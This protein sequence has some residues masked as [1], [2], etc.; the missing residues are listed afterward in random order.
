[1]AYERSQIL[2]IDPCIRAHR[3]RPC[4]P[5]EV[6]KKEITSPLVILIVGV[7]G[8][9]KTTSCAKLAKRYQ[10]EGKKRES[11]IVG[12]EIGKALLALGQKKEALVSCTQAVRILREVNDPPALR[13]ALLTMGQV[14]E[15]LDYFEEANRAYNQALEIPVSGEAVRTRILLLTRIGK[16][17]SRVGN[18]REGATRFEE[19]VKLTE[20]I[21]DLDLRGDTLGGYAQVLQQ[22]DEHFKAEEIF[23]H[24][25]R[26]WDGAGKPELSAYTYL[27]L[28]STY[29]AEG[30]LDKAYATIQ[31]AYSVFSNSSDKLGLALCEFH[32]ARLILRREQPE[33]A[34]QHGES[35]LKFFEKQKNFLAYAETALVVAQILERLVQDVRAL[36]LFD[37]AVEIFVYLKE[38][39]RELQTHV[40]KGKSLL[41]IGK[42]KDAEQEF[43]QAIRYY[44]EHTR[45]DQ[46][47]KIYVQVGEMFFELTQ[48]DEAVEQAKLALNLLQG[49]K[50]EGLEIR[51]Y[52]LL[53][54]AIKESQ[55]VEDELPFLQDGLKR[56][57][58][59]GKS[60]L[61]AKD[62]VGTGL[63]KG[64]KRHGHPLHSGHIHTVT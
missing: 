60:L 46:E 13:E 52:R 26:L 35:A 17:L 24:L 20:K 9:G 27:G 16:S 58:A 39:A 23:T 59:Q 44:Q 54:N 57:E 2:A 10:K 49:L 51:S 21:E 28:A 63:R 12:S 61:Q 45:A 37:K 55:R 14:M 25:I 6:E 36:R 29:L 3:G 1:M 50:E 42:R 7:N 30:Y 41:R 15:E 48:F 4:R 22:L 56:A 8:S 19:A 38:K 43:T 5:D 47:A 32:R 62:G 40:L 53:I 11:G 18:Y 31:Q 64:D 33:E 34:L